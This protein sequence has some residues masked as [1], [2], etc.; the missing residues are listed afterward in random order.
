MGNPR[1]AWGIDIGNR[2]LKAVKLVRDG[3]GALKVDD[4]EVIEHE[5]PLSSAGDNRDSLIQTALATFVQH[6]PSKGAVVGV[7][8]SGSSSLARF[9]KLPP[10]EEKK[11]PDIVRFE[12]IQ[13]IPFPLDDVEWSYQLFRTEGSP[14]VE[15]GIFAMRKELINHHLK[16]FT[17][18]GL[19]VNVV[20]LNPLAVYNAM[21]YDQ[22]IDGATMIIDLGSENTDLI[23][24]DGQSIWL[25]SIPVG[26]KSF[27]EVLVKQFKLNF[28]KAEELKRTAATSK[29]AK[30]IFQAMRP[31]FADLVAEI[32]RS[33]GFYASVHRDSRLKKVLAL[34]GTFRLPGLQK[35]IQQNLNLEV[36]RIDHFQAGAPAE[37][38][39]R[40]TFDD[41]LLS[42]A[43]AY[44]LAIQ[45]MGDSQITSSLLPAHI[46]REKMWKDK[47]PIFASAAACCVVAAGL[48]MGYYFLQN[49]SYGNDAN[50]TA[51]FHITDIIRNAK[52]LDDGWNND[53]EQQGTSDRQRVTNVQSM[54][55]YRDLWPGLY[56]DIRGALPA[57][58]NPALLGGDE[59][60]IKTAVPNRADRDILLINSMTSAWDTDLSKACGDP[61]VPIVQG[62]GVLPN[63]PTGSIPSGAHGF[64][65]VLETVTPF[66]QEP[67]KALQLVQTRF[68]TSLRA[69]GAT[70][71]AAKKEYMIVYA[72]V[73]SEQ[74]VGKNPAFKKVLTDRIA[75]MNAAILAANPAPV[76]VPGQLPPGVLP[77][78][79]PP[80]PPAAVGG[81]PPLGGDALIDPVSGEDM[82]R[83]T[84]LEV[85]ILAMTGAPG[86]LTP[87]PPVAP[88]AGATPAAAPA[89]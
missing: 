64:R 61:T 7:S 45:A 36:A 87:P 59:S 26:G 32:Q 4:F 8:V 74:P 50:T 65:I 56:R 71:A 17:D 75:T 63:C 89:N 72:D 57:P 54:L 62:S 9:I 44:G 18:V 13:Q 25:R 30:Q 35:Y 34:G 20:Q 52:T 1:S 53:V 84:V 85:T 42:M 12:A 27:T 51:R 46:R 66:G 68:L 49:M 11:I 77:P 81:Q 47:A 39:A 19:N 55:W 70:E 80:A 78:P 15:V 40:A 38:K 82:S 67:A 2:A 79:P 73:T 29:Y 10:V 3:S 6:K 22:R 41:N 31:V 69:L 24:A 88:P 23:I 60:K 33:I 37:G 28:A 76:V 86:T 5:T 16:V 48:S 21:Q 43:S 83:D 58:T 14:D